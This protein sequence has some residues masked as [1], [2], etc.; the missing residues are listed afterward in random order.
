MQS[1]ISEIYESLCNVN[2]PIANAARE[3]RHISLANKKIKIDSFRED[4]EIVKEYKKWYE[5][6]KSLNDI[7]MLIKK[8]SV[9][10]ITLISFQIIFLIC[11]NN[12]HALGLVYE[13]ICFMLVSAFQI[14]VLILLGKTI[15]IMVK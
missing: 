13:L 3:F 4:N 9:I 2:I 7:K 1:A 8:P 15:F 6:E 14:Y 5:Y 10:I 11:S 12:I